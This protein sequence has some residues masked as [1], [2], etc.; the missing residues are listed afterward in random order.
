MAKR[1]TEL[2]KKVII[3]DFVNGLTIDQ[4]SEKFSCT[5]LTIV[6]NLKKNLTESKYNSIFKKNK[7]TSFG[8]KG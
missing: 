5:K 6:R 4:L 3:N 8:D 7:D 2:Q 1:L